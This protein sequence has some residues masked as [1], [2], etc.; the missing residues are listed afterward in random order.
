[1]KKTLL[2]TALLSATA[3]GAQAS[4]LKIGLE[5]DPDALD[6]DKSRTFV[7]RIVFTSL[8]DK[9][10]DITPELSIVPQLATAWETSDDGKALTMT[11]RDGV[12][13]HDGTPFNAEAV[14]AN[15]ERSKTFDESVR[16]SE[17]SSIDTVEVVDALT[18]KFNLSASDATLLAQL[19]DRAGMMMAPSALSPDFASNPVC[20]GPFTLTERV[21]QDKIVLDKFAGYWNADAILLE[22]VTLVMIPDST[23]R[24][25]NLQSGD[26]QIVNQLSA[27][28]AAAVE[29]NARLRFANITGLGYQGLTFNGA[30]GDKS[31]NPLGQN[32][33]L[34]E[35]FDLSIDRDAIN[36][37]VFNGLFTPA[38]QP[39]TPASPYYNPD[40]PVIKRDIE[41][42]KA[43][44]AEAG[45]QTPVKVQVQVPN[46]PVTLQLM[47]VI[48]SMVAEAGF[49]VELV[50]KEF[51]TLIADASVGDFQ[52]SQQGWS[53]RVDPDGNI[54]GFVTTDAGFNDG[55][56]SNAEVDR[57][58]REA[59][60][61]SDPAARAERYKAATAILAVDR[62]L[63]YLYHLG[64]LYGLDAKVQGL[65]LYPDGMLRLEGV[66][67]TE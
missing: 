15:I 22:R 38:S 58:L 48:Q 46:T 54:F 55:K 4:E 59:R 17:L 60:T 26:I 37:V 18:V 3:L 35:A 42:A 14:K 10:V 40:F 66:S 21:S 5:S 30:N 53:G 8:C 62:P 64:W 36:Q 49:E 23:V 1:M 39:F 7:G 28:D 25:A 19:A 29:G 24:L 6:P 11:L 43:I 44:L 20:S 12:T 32:A 13:F 52:I 61:I 67:V 27:T 41:A 56:Y 16:K 51:A 2:L 57:L 45:V 9:L 31:N 47:Q 34:R 63:I 65:T 33:K 50:S